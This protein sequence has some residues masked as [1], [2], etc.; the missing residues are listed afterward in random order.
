M[1]VDASD[2]EP[3]TGAGLLGARGDRRQDD[4]HGNRRTVSRRFE[5]VEV[6]E[7]GEPR[8]PSYAPYLDLRPAT[9][10]ELAAIAAMVR[11]MT[12]LHDDV[13]RRALDYGIDVLSAEHLAE[14]RSRA[15]TAWPR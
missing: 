13:E 11:E 1:L 15:A 9:D 10:A 4:G 14:V 3:P 6:P 12:W 2:R 8:P 5:F 7:A